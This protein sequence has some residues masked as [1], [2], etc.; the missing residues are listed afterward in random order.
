[1]KGFFLTI[2]IIFTADSLAF[3]SSDYESY[4]DPDFVNFK[5][6]SLLIVVQN[7]SRSMTMEINERTEKYFSKKNISTSSY[8]QI[9]PPTRQWSAEEMSKR[10]EVQGIDGILIITVGAS[11][12]SVI[13]IATKTFSRT[14]ING[15]VNT[16]NPYNNTFNANA[17]TNSTSYNVYSAKSK[18]EF[19]AVLMETE[20]FRTAWYADVIVKA[21][22]T[23]FV[24]EK[25]DAKGVTKT[26]V[27]ALEKDG[28]IKKK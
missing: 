12:R 18:A 4:I 19:S 22:G 11:A 10:I 8:S 27:K 7:A 20:S 17:N 24:S 23:L 9:F 3:R 5:P 14:N 2:L 13:P 26:I 15:S 6:K 25:G 1:V 16:T 28:H 21:G